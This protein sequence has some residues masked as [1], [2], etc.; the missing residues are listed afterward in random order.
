LIFVLAV[1]CANDGETVSND[2]GQD[3]GEDAG[4]EPSVPELAPPLC[5]IELSCDSD[6]GDEPK[7]DCALRIADGLGAT[8][9]DD[10]AGLERRGRSS[11]VYDKPNYSL[12][13]RTAAGAEH[14]VDLLGMGQESD[15]ILDGLWVDRSLLRN[16]LVFALYRSLAAAGDEGTRWAPRGRFCELSLNGEARGIYRLGERIKRDDDRIDI[17]EDDGSFV[18]KQD[19]EGELR[20]DVGEEARWKL[21]SPDQ[22]RATDA[23]KESAQAFL[24]QLDGALQDDGASLFAL[25]DLDALADFVIVQELAKSADAYNLS[26]HLFRQSGA[27]AQLVPW[28]FD[29]SMGQPTSSNRPGT[30]LSSGWVPHRT[31][32]SDGLDQRAEFRA[33][34]AER[35]RAHRMGPLAESAIMALIERSLQTL[36]PAAVAA[37]FTRWP[38]EDVRFDH[39]YPP[40]TLYEV[41]SHEEEISRIK[42]WL[43]ARLTW[44]DAHIADYPN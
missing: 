38:I 35:W 22:E 5:Q 26:L 23:Q 20:W 11:Q 43:R 17:P 15:W 6:I 31:L 28:D 10:R 41:S 42:A 25:L 24:E 27:P 14:P 18:V 29:L 30:D 21:I 16:D 44:M 34:L 2:G 33:R 37:N 4:L 36:A 9:Y 19:S 39:I 3:A 40:Y 12:E 13:L 32:L 7:T 8:A 1:G